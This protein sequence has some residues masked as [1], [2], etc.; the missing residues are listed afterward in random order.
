MAIA[1]KILQKMHNIDKNPLMKR[2]Q[3]SK[4]SNVDNI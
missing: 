2:K 1:L 4:D 3:Y